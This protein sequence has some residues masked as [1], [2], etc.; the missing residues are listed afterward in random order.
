[1]EDTNASAMHKC[2]AENRPRDVMV[3]ARELT[4]AEGILYS[5][6]LLVAK[7]VAKAVVK[8][9]KKSSKTTDL[10]SDGTEQDKKKKSKT[11]I[12]ECVER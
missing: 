8:E 10:K 6:D 5:A 9:S 12:E 11:V 1:M 2:T 3:K 4:T 7:A